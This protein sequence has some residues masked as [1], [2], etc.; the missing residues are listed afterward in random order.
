MAEPLS[1]R[2]LR[3]FDA[4]ARHGSY[5]RA[6]EELGL[7]HGAI[8]HSIRELEFRT[9]HTLF[10]RS[11]RRMIPTSEAI[12][13]VT[14]VRQALDILDR[15]M[16]AAQIEPR[17]GLAISVHPGLSTRWFMARLRSFQADRPAVTIEVK[18]RHDPVDFLGADIDVAVRYGP[19][20]WPNTVA[21]PLWSEELFP[22]C[23]PAYRE[24]LDL[25]TPGD[26][27]RACLLGHQWQAWAPWL[28]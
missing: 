4:A 24:A 15:A 26:L 16:P 11:G 18:L 8:S 27:E 10:V 20:D 13:L 3:A 9:G 5:S 2:A 23:A 12:G 28:R 1:L 22:V 17:T 25:R 19:G 6:A 21:E 7:T 14:Q